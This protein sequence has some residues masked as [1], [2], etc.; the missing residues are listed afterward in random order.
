MDPPRSG[1]GS[2]NIPARPAEAHGRT[3]NDPP[4]VRSDID[5]APVLIGEIEVDVSGM[6]G[7]ADVDCP[8]R[9]VELR[10]RF[11]QVERRPDLRCARGLPGRLVIATAQPGPKPF[12]ADRPGFSVALDDDIGKCGADSGVKQLLTPRDVDEHIARQA[13]GCR[14][15]GHQH[16][17]FDRKQD[18]LPAGRGQ[19]A[20]KLARP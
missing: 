8:F 14:R 18:L 12:A 16:L 15:Y 4:S 6:L 1:R 20:P 7:G 19:F 2:G 5:G 17:K 3:F 11:E 13:L 9:A 10:P